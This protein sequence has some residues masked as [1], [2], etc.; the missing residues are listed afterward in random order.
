[1]LAAGL[2]FIQATRHSCQPLVLSSH[3]PS[4]PLDSEQSLFGMLLTSMLGRWTLISATV[5]S[6]RTSLP[7]MVVLLSFSP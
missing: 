4:A 3:P 2:I 6:G 1:L 5:Q 7:G